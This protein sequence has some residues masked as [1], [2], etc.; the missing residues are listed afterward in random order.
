MFCFV[1]YLPEEHKAPLRYFGP[2]LWFS[3]FEILYINYTEKAFHSVFDY[4]E[5]FRH[6]NRG[7]NEKLSQNN[8][9]FDPRLWT[10]TTTMIIQTLKNLDF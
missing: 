9:L 3:D 7:P 2:R 10:Q 4:S 1:F 5:Y 6:H 8:L